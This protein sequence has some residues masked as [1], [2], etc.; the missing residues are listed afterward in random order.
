MQDYRLSGEAPDLFDTSTGD[1]KCAARDRRGVTDMQIERF[2]MV[3]LL[4]GCIAACGSG[5]NDSSSSSPPPASGGANSG[6]AAPIVNLTAPNS[7]EPVSGEL[8]LSV[9]LKSDTTIARVVF[10]VDDVVIAQRNAA[11]FT[12]AWNTANVS[13]GEH[14]LGVTATDSAGRSGTDAATVRTRNA[15]VRK[16]PINLTPFGAKNPDA[17]AVLSRAEIFGKLAP[18]RHR[19][20]CVRTFGVS[21]GLDVVPQVAA[22]LGIDCVAV[23]IWLGSDPAA[24][25][26]EIAKAVAL[27]RSAPNVRYVA[28]GSETLLRGDLTADEL[29]AYIERVQA[30]LPGK[31][32]TTSET[33]SGWLDHPQLVDAVS[34]VWVTVYPFLGRASLDVAIA[35]LD[36]QY[37]QLQAHADGKTI[38]IVESGWPTCGSA[39]GDAIP[40]EANSASYALNFVSWAETLGVPYFLFGSSD[41]SYKAAAH[42]TAYE[43]CWG[44]TKDDGSLKAGM[45]HLFAGRVMADNWSDVPKGPTL[46]GPRG[47]TDTVSPVFRWSSSRAAQYRFYVIDGADKTTSVV[48]DAGSVGCGSGDNECAYTPALK[49][50]PDGAQWRVQSLNAKGSGLWSETAELFVI[51]CSHGGEMP[52]APLPVAPIDGDT[53]ATPTLVFTRRS[54][55]DMDPASENFLIQVNDVNGLTVNVAGLTREMLGCAGD[56]KC[57]YV[58]AA[59]AQGAA[60]WRVAGWTYN[61]GPG[62][63]S[64]CTPFKVIECGAGVRPCAPIPTSPVGLNGMGK[65]TFGFLPVATAT[66]YTIALTDETLNI[67]TRRGNVFSAIELGCAD[68][69]SMCTV[70]AEHQLLGGRWSVQAIN[71]AGEAGPMSKPTDYSIPACSAA[72]GCHRLVVKSDTG[73][74]MALDGVTFFAREGGAG[75]GRG[76]CVA[77][78][79]PAGVVVTAAGRE[80]RCFDTWGLGMV[81][82]SDLSTRLE[83]V[84]VNSYAAIAFGDDAGAIRTE[85]GY[86]MLEALGATLVRGVD[87]RD[88]YVLITRNRTA[89]VEDYNLSPSYSF[90]Y[91]AVFAEF[92]R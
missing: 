47:E 30:E 29:I 10:T 37:R 19:A 87:F 20:S 92:G 7:S 26:S 44:L 89:L 76:V 54:T 15:A 18:W 41:E 81:A 8:Q 48:L 59:L 2:A 57:E 4:T 70:Q 65:L 74:S 3:L 85:Q 55:A 64:A 40:S 13:D 71:A 62:P 25:E 67:L 27:V 23:T 52:C 77:E 66:Q 35:V 63:W 34:E 28:V 72:E 56:R 53:D 36:S 31:I 68:G 88:P 38:V 73:V 9:D 69:V 1:P 14:L 11:P 49:L 43:G 24:N 33:P 45:E 84:D 79:S 61:T 5:G 80:P 86:R 58:S 50:S 83:K 21:G 46:I 42:A 6:A 91:V 82:L 75:G 32:V 39:V 17:G 90:S 22:E 16:I 78:V 12:A 60:C 51:P